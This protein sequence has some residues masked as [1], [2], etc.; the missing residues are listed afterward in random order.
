MIADDDRDATPKKKG[1]GTML[2]QNAVK[3]LTKAGWEPAGRHA[4]CDAFKKDGYRYQIE[5]PRDE[6]IGCV[7]VRHGAAR[8]VE[9]YTGS[10]HWPNLA[11]ALRYAEEHG[12]A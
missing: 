8:P 9:D 1:D 10:S 3:R 12:R 2:Y 7:W 6:T 11:Q 5:I 4:G